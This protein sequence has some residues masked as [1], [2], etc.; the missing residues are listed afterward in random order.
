MANLFELSTLQTDP[1]RNFKFLVNFTLNDGKNATIGPK[2]GSMGFVSV[3][4]LS[5]ATEA[6]SYREGGYNT[7]MHQIPGQSS[8][9]P[10]TLSKG[11]ALGQ[12]EHSLWMKRL[13]SVLTGA[14]G[15]AGVGTEF[16]CTVD[17]S[18]L[19]HPNPKG[20]SGSDSTATV[21]EAKNQHT[22]MRFRVYNAWVTSLA[23]SNLD[24]GG[25]SLMVEEMTLVHE[26]FDVSFATGYK[27]AEDA[28]DLLSV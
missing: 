14:Q 7:N 10:I 16:R 11:I 12:S 25:S 1:F 28:P 22:A 24:A 9:T 18:V 20:V 5:V 8:F 26:G 15:V 3:S 27:T 19:S 21:A 2:F 13:F 23:Y 6:I 17:I 4:G